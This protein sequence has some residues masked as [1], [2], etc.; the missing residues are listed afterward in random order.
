MGFDALAHELEKKSSD[1][2]RAI[3]AAAHG[4]A[5]EIVDSAQF[6]AKAKVASAKNEV[7]SFLE[8]EKSERLTSAKL[9]C[10]K[11]L[12]D[13]REGAVSNSLELV[14]QQMQKS[15][16]APSYKKLLSALLAQGIEE[17]GTSDVVLYANEADIKHLKGGRHKVLAA[18]CTGGVIIEK[19]D[20]SVR[21]DK[22]F[23][24]IFA[25]GKDDLRKS[26]FSMLF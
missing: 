15:R 8:A 16:T 24:A 20:G 10:S 26:I 22:S 2:A 5:K 6:S 7:A 1:E 23:E 11:I 19:R 13:A 9:Q 14:W 4:Q 17:L 12:S 3:V 25:E 18:N 21:V